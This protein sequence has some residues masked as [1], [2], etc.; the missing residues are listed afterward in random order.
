VINMY[1]EVFTVLGS[2][3]SGG[4]AGAIASRRRVIR[5]IIERSPIVAPTTSDPV[6]DSWI[7]QAASEWSTKFGQP[8]AKRL[9]ANKLRLGS[10]L[11][12]QRQRKDQS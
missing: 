2:I 6:T 10:R 1:E 11:Q 5:S 12:Q 3:V 8:D 7:D 4:A 9:I